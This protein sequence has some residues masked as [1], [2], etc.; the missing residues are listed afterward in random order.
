MIQPTFCL[1]P[2]AV[3]IH[4]LDLGSLQSSVTKITVEPSNVTA[5]LLAL[6]LDLS[7][8]QYAITQGYLAR[9]DLTENHPKIFWGY[10]MWAQTVSA[11]RDILRSK[12]WLKSDIRNY[13]LTISPNLKV[14]IV[15]TTGDEGT[16]VA[17]LIPSNKCPKGVNTVAAINANN[18][19]LLLPFAEFSEQTESNL[20]SVTWVLL[21]HLAKDEIRSE[22][23]LPSGIHNKK[24]SAW[25]ERIILPALPRENTTVEIQRPELPE[26]DV[27]IKR[28]A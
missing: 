17:H 18:K 22:L 12:N 19:Q 28:K 4:P 24:I 2:V 16:G 11:L 27:P 20:G 9:T 13:E 5:R 6:G 15:V 14:A 7:D 1:E 26:I 21:V 8:L 23:S 3:D 10:S 25:A